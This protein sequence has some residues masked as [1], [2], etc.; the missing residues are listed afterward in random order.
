MALHG[1]TGSSESW[2]RVDAL[3][4][5]EVLETPALLGHDPELLHASAS[6][7]EEVDRI[8]RR[9]AAPKRRSRQLT[10]PVEP[11]HLVG[12]SLGARVAMGWACRHPAQ[13]KS[14]T[15]I[16]GHPG[17]EDPAQRAERRDSDERWAALL[18]TRGIFAFVEQWETL[19]LFATQR[20]LPADVRRAH[21]LRRTQHT[22][23][24]LA[25]SL[26]VLGLGQ[27][28][29]RWG[30]LRELQM[31]L[32][33]IVGSLDS[34]FWSLAERVRALRDAQPNRATELHIV[35]GVGHDVVLEAPSAVAHL[36]KPLVTARE[37][38][39]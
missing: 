18:D 16:G 17:L 3:L 2:E 30:A 28:T 25:Q 13:V 8:A 22:A 32:S 26:R 12:Y 39:R 35:E 5:G 36:L 14:L 23:L 15:L 7:D 20:S 11:V 4:G 34:K 37:G 29:P 9:L 6:F 21:R 31:P 27:M 33:L 1:F 19:P 24:G 38:R 10:R